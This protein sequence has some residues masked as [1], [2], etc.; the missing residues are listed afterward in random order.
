MTAR[1]VDQLLQQC[2]ETIAALPGIRIDEVESAHSTDRDTVDRVVRASI[3]NR[4]LLIA[5]EAKNSG[6]P[7]DAQRAAA[8]LKTILE[9]WEEDA[10]GLMAAPF[11]TPQARSQLTQQSIGYWDRSG[12]LYLETPAALYDIERPALVPS[13]R[14]LKKLFQGSA[15][16]VIHALL[17]EPERNWK[18][19]ELAD[20]AEVAQSHAHDVLKALEAEEFIDRT[21]SG[22]ATRRRLIAPGRLLDSWAE[23]YSLSQFDIETFYYWTSSE[24]KLAEFAGEIL[25]SAEIE[26]AL[27]ATSGAIRRE[28]YVWQESVTTIIV[29]N[30]LTTRDALER[31]GVSRVDEGENLVILST[32]QRS[33]LMYRQKV[34][35]VWLASDIQIYLDLMASPGRG[36]DQAAHL[37]QH[38]IRF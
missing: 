18:V 4:P 36:K 9:R 10:V 31:I 23:T 13:K 6:Y 16:Q 22:P 37:R 27:T 2:I 32:Q 5:I 28:P 34:G 30:G 12:S 29:N 35:Q 20:R 8:Q 14:P 3:K 1:A 38:K 26:F 7:R 25:R 24:E 11:I 17:I 19:I 15:A 21:G 33:P